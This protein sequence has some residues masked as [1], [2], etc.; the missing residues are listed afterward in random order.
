MKRIDGRKVN[1]LRPIRITKNY[2]KFATGSVL[3]EMGLTRVICAAT[4]QDE[5]PRWLK[6]RGQGWITAEYSM[7]PYASNERKPREITTGK[8][9]GRTHE[10]QRLIGRSLRGVIDMKH[11]GERTVWIDCDVIQAD[12]GT[13]T[14][15]ITG[16][17]LALMLALQKIK[18][19]GKIDKMPVREY[20]GAV[21]V[22]IL[23]GTPILDLCYE[24][25][26]KA[27]VD[28]NFVITSE[29]RFIEIQGTAEHNPFTQED[30]QKLLKLA[31]VGMK[32]IFHIQ[33]EILLS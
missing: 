27:E 24:E 26:S 17:F 9:G 22:G 6:G 18:E 23:D 7:L 28:M 4:V 14:A 13:R 16:G 19:E 31:Q 8:I 32:K 15:S 12:G 2:V 25:D 29:G 3:I 33:K 5:V 20:V 1:E 11:L 30:L 21:S 10:I